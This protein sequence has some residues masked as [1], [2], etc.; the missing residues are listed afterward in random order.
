MKNK[1]LWL[2]VALTLGLN[3]S[4]FTEAKRDCDNNIAQGCHTLGYIYF[5]EKNNKT[6]GLKFYNKASSLGYVK[7]YVAMAY[8]YDEQGDDEK[9]KQYLKKACN[10]GSDL[11]CGILGQK[12]FEQNQYKKASPFLKKA[13]DSRNLG[14]LIKQD[15][16]QYLE[17]ISKTV[18]GTNTDAYRNCLMSN[19]M[20]SNVGKIC[21]KALPKKSDYSLLSE[22]NK[23]AFKKCL[24]KEDIPVAMTMVLSGSSEE[25]CAIKLGLKFISTNQQP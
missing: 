15:A 7:S 22:K 14:K 18:I 6:L 21:L 1:L 8:I 24:N 2:S 3:A 16:C 5:A 20:Y 10:L 13:C 4:E 11:G 17:D 9:A 19:K 12:Y 25:A 23:R